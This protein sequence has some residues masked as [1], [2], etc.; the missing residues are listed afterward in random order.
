MATLAALQHGVVGRWQ[1]TAA[2]F[3][4]DVIQGLIDRGCLLGIH[5]GVYALGHRRLTLK[6]RWM[7]AV[8]AGGP[9]ALLSHRAAVALW[10]LRP[11]PSGATDV[12]LLR[13]GRRKRAALRFH[14]VRRLDPHDRAVVDGIPVTSLHRTLLDYAEIARPQELRLALEAADRL[15]LLDGRKLEE[16]YGRSS[17][18]RG[19]RTLKPA[20]AE[21]RGPAPWTQSE[22]ERAF[23]ALVRESGLPEPSCNVLVG[24]FLV[25]CWWPRAQLVVEIDG[26][27]FHKSRR[28]FEAN[29]LRDTKLQLAGI[30]V[31]RVTQPRIEHGPSE[32]V[33]D[34]RRGLAAAVA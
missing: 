16:L 33:S 12:T 1:L 21:L 8:L 10:E 24:G 30:R 7:A 34:L 32:L 17:G 11:A 15:E 19:L 3:S 18:R 23:L 6:G 29:R 4:R 14:G 13:R 26:Y 5:R 20:V 2:G 22:L 9:G 31:L 28:E 27:A 25:D